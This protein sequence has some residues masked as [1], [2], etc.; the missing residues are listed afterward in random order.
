M[1]LAY[2]NLRGTKVTDLTPLKGAPL[3]EVYLD[4]SSVSDL[5]P[6]KGTPIETLVMHQALVADLTP[7]EGMPLKT[8][9]F[10]PARAAKGIQLIRAM[11]SLGCIGA[12]WE[13]RGQ[14]AAEF[15]KRYDAGELRKP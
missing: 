3:R 13:Q 9:I 10:D 15:W 6:L 12:T 14:P 1:P 11:K 4:H 8:L 7:L 2:F 5:A